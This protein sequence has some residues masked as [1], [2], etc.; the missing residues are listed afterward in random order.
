MKLSDYKIF[1]A[2]VGLTGILLIA[3]PVLGVIVH[4]PR[5]EMFS[6]LYILGPGRMAENFP[7]NIA[8]GEVYHVYVGARNHMGQS[9]YYVIYVKFGSNL[10]PLP[11]VTS[12][13][14]SPLP[15]LFEYR[16]LLSDEATF[17][18]KLNFSITNA[19]FIDNQSIV[20]TIEIN[21]VKF[22][23]DKSRVW[24]TEPQGFYY[25]LIMELWI[26]NDVTGQMEFAN[27]FV[28]LHLNVTRNTS[29]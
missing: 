10:D 28:Y 17:E 9:A 15:P 18:R 27:R 12:G 1:F 25:R 7:F 19:D 22:N 16:F 24:D 5:G 29:R 20:N 23:V 8:V 4:F 3:S 26:F 2:A 13:T 11:N 14:P 21:G 6:E